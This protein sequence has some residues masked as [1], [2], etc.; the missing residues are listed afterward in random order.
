MVG[1]L[2]LTYVFDF[3]LFLFSFALPRLDRDI[4]NNEK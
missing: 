1:L 3:L 4:K 2:H